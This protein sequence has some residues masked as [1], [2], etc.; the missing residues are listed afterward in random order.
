MSWSKPYETTDPVTGEKTTA[1]HK[2]DE[3]GNVSDFLTG[4]ENDSKEEP[5]NHGHAWN[6]NEDLPDDENKPDPIGG[7]DPK[8]PGGSEK[9]PPSDNE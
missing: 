4:K 6:L 2:T 5:K 7:R 8:N 9:Y 3:N 1:A